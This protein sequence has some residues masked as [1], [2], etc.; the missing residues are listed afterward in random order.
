MVKQ[1]DYIGIT[2]SK[3]ELAQKYGIHAETLR[4]WFIGNKEMMIKLN[5]IGYNK[6]RNILT[7]NE[8]G[9]IREYLGF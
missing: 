7:P 1:A 9:I 3:S 5:A 6:Y 8:L 4:R 2:M